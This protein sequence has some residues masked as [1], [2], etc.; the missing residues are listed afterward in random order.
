MQQSIQVNARLI[1]F[2][3]EV[4]GERPTI[5]IVLN[6]IRRVYSRRGGGDWR[7]RDTA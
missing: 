1:F 2:F 4:A 7:E 5:L 6:K 3:F